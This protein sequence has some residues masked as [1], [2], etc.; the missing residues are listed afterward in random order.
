MKFWMI[1]MLGNICGVLLTTLGILIATDADYDDG[2]REDEEW[3]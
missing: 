1:F 2:V 3:E